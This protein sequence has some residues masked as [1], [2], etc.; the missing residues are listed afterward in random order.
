MKALGRYSAETIRRTVQEE[1]EI[2]VATEAFDLLSLMEKLIPFILN[3]PKPS[4]FI[5]EKTINH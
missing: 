4:P 2:M 3:L 5:L 1:K